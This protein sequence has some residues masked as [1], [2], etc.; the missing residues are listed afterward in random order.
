VTAGVA[1]PRPHT[2][3]AVNIDPESTNRIHSDEVARAYGFA[4]ALVPGVELFAY[5]TT[6][7]VAAWGEAFLERGR[8]DARF[9]S[10]VYDGEQVYVRCSPPRPDGSVDVEL[11]GPDGDVRA[12]ATA[13]PDG[14]GSL[15][16]P[17][18]LRAGSSRTGSVQGNPVEPSALAPG[19]LPSVEEPVELAALQ[20]YLSAVGDRSPL[21]SAGHR[22]HPGG[23]LRMVNALLVR[24]V[25]LGPWIHTGSRCEFLGVAAAPCQLAAHG[26]VERC[27]ER[28][29]RAWVRYHALVEADR[30]PVMA[31]EHT[32]IYMLGD[33]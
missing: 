14:R 27:W 6:P 9:R 20:R 22:V 18:T 17:E 32:A 7:L 2:V 1:S 31:V 30:R 3:T 23:L 4:G 5:L 21:Y 11:C 25:R 28:N 13:A 15:G 26:V 19:P 12:E 16:L 33:P 24:N 8:L 10:P 29:G